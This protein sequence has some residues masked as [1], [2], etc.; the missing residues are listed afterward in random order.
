MPRP[1]RALGVAELHL[2]TGGDQLRDEGSAD[3]RTADDLDAVSRQPGRQVVN[4]GEQPRR[5]GEQGVEIEPEVAVVTRLQRK[6]AF[7]AGH[8]GQQGVTG[9]VHTLRHCGVHAPSSTT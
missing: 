4:E 2:E 1:R 3:Q 5:P 7:A 6:M 8:Q 9:V